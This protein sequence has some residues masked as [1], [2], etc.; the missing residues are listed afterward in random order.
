MDGERRPFRIYLASDS[1][2]TFHPNNTR[3]AFGVH[4]SEGIKLRGEYQVAITQVIA[5]NAASADPSPVFIY[6]SISTKIYLADSRARCLRI[7][8]PLDTSTV[9]SF[10][11]DQLNFETVEFPEFQD[12]YVYLKNREGDSYNLASSGPPTI[13]TLYFRPVSHE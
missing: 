10:E 4:L 12:I 8:P 13:V 9:N 5:T 6:S 7:L 11:F 1:S 3:A 2:K